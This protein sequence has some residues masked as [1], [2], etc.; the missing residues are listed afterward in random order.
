MNIDHITTINAGPTTLIAAICDELQLESTLN[1]LLDWHPSYWKVSPGTHIK[2]MVINILCARSPLYQVEDFYSEHDVPLLFG[3]QRT[4]HDFND[5]AL[6][7]VLDLVHEAES[8]KV[9]STWSLSVLQRLGLSLSP[10][11]ND[12]T[13]FSATGD[14]PD[15][16]KLA[17]T[18]GYSKDKRPDLKQILIGMGVTPERLPVLATVD[19]GNT[20]DKTWNFEFITRMRQVLS[21]EQW[22]ELT[23]VADSALV[24]PDNLALLAEQG[25][26]FLTRLPDTYDIAK[27]LRQGAVALNQWEDHGTLGKAVG[28]SH[29]R[30]KASP[31]TCTGRRFASSWSIRAICTSAKPARWILRSPKNARRLPNNWKP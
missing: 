5:D 20:N 2:A 25:A 11:H 1:A 23:Y 4:S 16:D 17:I 30:P 3:S 29:Y 13:S 9:Y 12:T 8:W 26:A 22:A 19:N 15:T 14:Y 28:S 18:Y 6:A 31:E 21:D 7:R 10:V 24:T 27:E